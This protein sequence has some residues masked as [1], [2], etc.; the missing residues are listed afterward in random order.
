MTGSMG[1]VLVLLGGCAA[2]TRTTG[3]ST[4]G[5]AAAAPEETVLS[6]RDPVTRSQLRER[7][8]DELMKST[9]SEWSLE[10]ANAIEGMLEAPSRVESVAAAGLNDGN[11]GVRSVAAMVVGKA[12]LRGLASSVRGLVHDES[13]YVRVSSIFALASLGED[14]DRT[15]LSQML[16]DER[17][18]HVRAHAAYILGELGDRSALTMLGE[19]ASTTTPGATE[20]QQKLLELQIAE[21][22]VKLG[23]RS[24]LDPIRAALLPPSPEMLE[25][26]ALAAQIIGTLEDRESIDRLINLS[27]YR[28]QR[29]SEAPAEVMLAVAGALSQLGLPKGTFIADQ[30]ASSSDAAVRAQAAFV[31]G[32]IGQVDNLGKLEAMLGDESGLTRVAAATGVLRILRQQPQVSAR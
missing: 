30:F 5:R 24:Q 31:Y 3:P 1:C 17:S 32:Q 7:A 15:P 27:A 2:G 18:T 8:L 28:G 21:A 19:A 22:M 11:E 9:S 4:T 16:F 6:Y 14:V 29:G 23:E 10:R 13:D 20:I 12:K 25:A 26:S